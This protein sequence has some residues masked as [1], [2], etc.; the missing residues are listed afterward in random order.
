MD[1]QN[2]YMNHETFIVHTDPRLVKIIQLA[3]QLKPASLLDVGCGRGFLLSQLATKIDAELYGI[4]VYE[5]ESEGWTYKKGDLTKGLPFGD[6]SFELV[7]FGEV[8]EHLPD[9]DYLLEEIWRVLK[10]GGK[11]IVT[12][13]NL[14]SWANRILLPFGIQPLFT[15]TSSRK[16][17]GRRFKVLGQGGEVQGHLRIFTKAALEEL[18]VAC[19]FGIDGTWGVPFFFPFPVSKFDEFLCRFPSLSSGLFVMAH[20]VPELSS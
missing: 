3:E 14:A 20:K 19:G 18:V 5:L 6:D 9:P 10:P 12:T 13:P 4:D 1:Y 17:M 16:K 8:I 15:E 11:V 2:F 7:V